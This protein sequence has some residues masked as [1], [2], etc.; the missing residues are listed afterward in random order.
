MTVN[1]VIR[2]RNEGKYLPLCLAL[3]KKQTYKNFKITVVDSGS[4]DLT[5]LAA[6]NAECNLVKLQ[7]YNPGRAINLGIAE[8]SDCCDYSVI[9]SAHCLPVED[10]WLQAFVDFMAS[11][12]EIA[13]AYGAQLPMNYT[14]MDD[15][16][17]LAAVLRGDTGIRS[18]K[19]FHNA[20]SIVRNS[21]WKYCPFT[22]EY[23]HIEDIVWAQEI[24]RF[25]KKIGYVRE[26]AVT[27]YH[28]LNQHDANESFRAKDLSTFSK[29]AIL[30]DLFTLMTCFINQK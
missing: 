21:I 10:T 19:F 24:E 9:I 26:A 5:L 23:D 8:F 16:R 12:D 27:H 15:T 20:N 7:S 11:D 25:N 2:T 18:D 30:L 13:G 29:G 3:I 22:E 1:I 14:N 6:Q 28:G 4:D 17:D